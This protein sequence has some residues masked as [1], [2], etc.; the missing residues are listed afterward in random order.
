M[1][2]KMMKRRA[3]RSIAL[4]VVSLCAGLALLTGS[5]VAAS[6]LPTLTLAVSKNAIKVGGSLTSGAVN[7]AAT[8]TGEP[9]DNPG[10]F[11]LKPGVTPAEF[12]K[13]VSKLPNN[14]FDGIAAYGTIVYDA[15]DIFKGKPSDTEVVLAPGTYVALNNGNG[16]TVFTVSPATAPASLPKPDATVTAIDFRFK[17]AGTLHDGEL[18]RF[19]NAGFLL[20]MFIFAQIKSAA[21]AP[22]AE[23]L[24]LQ[25]KAKE[26][27]KLYGTGLTGAFAGPLSHDAMQQEVITEPPGVYVI[28]C[29]MTAEDGLPHY[30]LGMFRTLRIVK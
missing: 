3:L 27:T 22:K 25:G 23:A 1:G 6:S 29:A 9:E 18:V 28:A 19:R 20:H 30:E 5:S 11:L 12:G 7:I 21:D 8:V 2:P 4:G 17:G 14:Q 15:Q 10:L 24:L 26:A 16:H 13:G